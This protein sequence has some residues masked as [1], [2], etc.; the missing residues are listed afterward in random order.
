V[1]FSIALV[2]MIV[3]RK[4]PIVNLKL[5]Y[6]IQK[7]HEFNLNEVIIYRTKN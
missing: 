2:A 1:Q 7:C 4:I 3:A 6:F 5:N